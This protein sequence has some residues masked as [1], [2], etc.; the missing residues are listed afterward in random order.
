MLHLDVF[1]LVVALLTNLILGL[2]VITRYPESLT[3]RLFFLLVLSMTVWSLFNYLS[4]RDA[5]TLLYARLVLFFAVAFATLFFFFVITFPKKD[6]TVSKQA[7]L[8]CS[9][10]SLIVMVLTLSP[11][12]FKGI[13]LTS[14]TGLG[15]P[16]V[17]PGIGIFG[18]TV[19]FYDFGGLFIFAKK[20][21]QFRGEEKIRRMY[22][23]TG[24]ALMLL[25]IIVFNFILPSAFSNTSFI[26]Y[27]P[28]FIIPFMALTSYAI[29][30][31]HLLDIRGAA[32]RTLAYILSL[33][34]IGIIYGLVVYVAIALIDNVFHSGVS[35]RAIYIVFALLTGLIYQKV[36][37][38]FDHVTNRIFFKDSYD[39]QLLI[40][41]LTDILI[42]NILLEELLQ[43]TG[44]L[45]EDTTKAS[46]VSFLLFGE[47]QVDAKRLIG[48]TK[49]LISKEQIND[50]ATLFG[51]TR[52]EIIVA[53]ELIDQ[54][55]TDL[56]RLIDEIGAALIVK[57]STHKQ[58]IGYMLIGVKQSGDA[59]RASDVS[60]LGIIS[61]EVSLAIQNALRF[62]E[63][64]NFNITLQEKIDQATQQLRKANQRLKALDETKDDFI[65]M[66]SHQLR[67]PLTSVKGYISMVLDGDA[68]KISANQKKFLSQAFTSSQ[69]MVY[70]IADLLNVSRLK[71]GK[72]VIEP[73]LTNLAEVVKDEIAQLSETAESRKLTLTYHKPEHFPTLN[74][75][76]TKTRQVMMNFMDNAIY[77]T[78]SGGHIDVKL[79]D[80]PK[81][82]QFTVT[83]DG[84]GVPRSEEH[85]LFTKFYRAG[86][87]QKARPDGTGLGLFMAKKVVIAQGGAI[88]FH[89]QEGKGSTFGFSFPKD[90]LLKEATP[91][92]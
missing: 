42:S 61:D 40:D 15:K 80:N 21:I 47:E 30:K 41:K 52:Q 91:D 50:M 82:I 36:K 37:T 59:Y 17:G 14:E 57:L 71:T 56:H 77:Y 81:D 16:I 33:G 20:T 67:T 85:H 79:V 54:E 87:A 24:L 75:D 39:P 73:T 27:A 26:P 72:F 55:N 83:D 60:V 5:N 23:L 25:M 4:Y 12:V 44:K 43:R 19:L 10:W 58:H 18:L 38:F 66:A 90:K 68:G 28:A 63:I 69:R 22:L 62:E 8:L 92:K 35:Q 2:L 78:P 84:I 70:L 6:L 86:N 45:I 65:S 53:D 88:I 32:S 76:E 46:Y 34:F 13:R 74:I 49:R 3:N 51:K 7:I 29:V 64:Q 48:N 89:S 11:F 9:L 1:I 31:H